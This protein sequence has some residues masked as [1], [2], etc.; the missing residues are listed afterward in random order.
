M[1]KFFAILL[2]AVMLTAVMSQ[3]GCTTTPKTSDS[4]STATEEEEPLSKD[5]YLSPAETYNL[6][7]QL[8]YEGYDL[9]TVTVT[10]GETTTSYASSSD[11]LLNSEYFTFSDGVITA[12]DIEVEDI[13]TSAFTLTSGDTIVE[14]TVNIVNRE[15]YGDSLMKVDM[16]RLYGKKVVFLGDSITDDYCAW[17]SSNTWTKVDK[18]GNRVVENG[19]LVG[20]I[21]GIT[22]NYATMLDTLCELSSYKNLAIAG[23]LASYYE[24]TYATRSISVPTQLKNN[25][26]SIKEADYVFVMVGTND[27]YEINK[28]GAVLTL[29]TT[30]DLATEDDFVYAD[31]ATTPN[32]TFCA[33]YNYILNLIRETNSEAGLIALSNI[34]CQSN[35]GYSG[36]VSN[37]HNNEGIKGVNAA[38]KEC[39]SLYNAV[40]IDLYSSLPASA[41]SGNY[42]S[43][44]FTN[45]L[46]HPNEAAYERMTDK[47]LSGE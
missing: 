11:T 13:L 32:N 34:P 45:D 22:Q 7:K 29:G 44:W 9:D 1:K 40:Y 25:L 23:A 8:E 33:Y 35:Y 17:W 6:S 42:D 16:G 18:N 21:T 10:T 12:N 28:S 46:L 19:K 20:T 24:A 37:G 31:D 38:I 30:T 47:I 27:S 2:T 15:K 41:R 43:T 26:S 5:I 14:Y 36:G 39:S 3:V 4:S